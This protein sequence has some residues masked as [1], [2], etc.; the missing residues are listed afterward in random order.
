MTAA[1]DFNMAQNKQNVSTSPSIWE[2]PIPA[3][4]VRDVLLDT[5]Q[6][7]RMHDYNPLECLDLYGELYQPEIPRMCSFYA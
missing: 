7:L 4:E 2:G 6:I 3:S 5:I 1:S